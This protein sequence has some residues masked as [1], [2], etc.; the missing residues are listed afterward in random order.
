MS[1]F[2]GCSQRSDRLKVPVLS[3]L[4]DALA[5]E[6]HTKM[7][8]ETST[9]SSDG[10]LESILDETANWTVNGTHGVVLCEVASLRLAI[11]KAAQFAA[12]GREVV[13]LMRRR[14]P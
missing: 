7:V 4:P 12:T 2:R 8:A 5:T 6:R 14:P 13:A 11:A 3:K 1:S 10:Q 9:C